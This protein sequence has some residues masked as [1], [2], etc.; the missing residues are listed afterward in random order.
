MECEESFITMKPIWH[1]LIWVGVAAL[2]WAIWNTR[3]DI[4]FYKI[5]Y[6]SILQVIFRG[7]Y[8]LH[9]WAQ[10]QRDEHNKNLLSS[11]STRIEMVSLEQAHGGWKHLYRLCQFVVLICEQLLLSFIIV[12]IF[13]AVYVSGR[14]GQI[15]YPLSKKIFPT[16]DGL[17]LIGHES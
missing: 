8:W 5:K 14:R 15:F 11:L 2:C 12:V 7:T 1:N 3:N 6:N 9:F 10:L 16:T 13:G 17:G 4:V